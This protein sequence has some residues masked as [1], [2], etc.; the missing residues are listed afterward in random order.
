MEDKEIEK[1]ERERNGSSHTI[2]LIYDVDKT[3]PEE[4]D[5]NADDKEVTNERFDNR[6]D[7]DIRFPIT[8]RQRNAVQED[9]TNLRCANPTSSD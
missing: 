6:Y 3:S 9:Y 7:L 4:V 5:E 8:Q 1:E 2:S